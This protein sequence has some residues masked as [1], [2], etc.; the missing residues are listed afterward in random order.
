MLAH[1]TVITIRARPATCVRR[2]R[3]GGRALARS[4]SLA[5]WP[6][7][8]ALRR[9][10]SFPQPMRLGWRNALAF[11]F[12][13]G[14]S[15]RA[16]RSPE[17]AHLTSFLSLSLFFGL[18]PAYLAPARSLP[19]SS[20]SPQCG[21]KIHSQ[22]Y[23]WGGERRARQAHRKRRRRGRRRPSQRKR[24]RGGRAGCC[25]RSAMRFAHWRL[26]PGWRELAAGSRKLAAC[27]SMRGRV[28]A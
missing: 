20:P 19:F 4:P 18:A 7:P 13:P 17:A 14:R 16:S 2:G 22:K 27:R 11:C 24:R 8:F 12:S 28:S 15:T 3:G 26:L 9:S 6:P 21:R 1:G 23:S 5:P 10:I 25:L